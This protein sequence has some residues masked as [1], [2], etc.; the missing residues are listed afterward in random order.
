MDRKLFNKGRRGEHRA[1]EKA[2]AGLRALGATIV[3]SRRGRRA[4]CR[5]IST[6]Y[7]AVGP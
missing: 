5:N 7:A 2:V 3:D 1:A 6:S 4:C